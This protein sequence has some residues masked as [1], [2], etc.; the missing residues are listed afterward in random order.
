M[1]KG[2]FN[3]EFKKDLLEQALRSI[4]GVVKVEAISEEGL[5]VYL[6]SVS[7]DLLVGVVQIRGKDL[8]MSGSAQYF[9]TK[10]LPQHYNATAQMN[11]LKKMGFQTQ[12]EV[13]GDNI[14]IQAVK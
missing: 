2:K 5:M 7:G 10:K 4:Q 1:S 3:G 9:L 11:I 12:V 13:K 14:R 8:V 6:K